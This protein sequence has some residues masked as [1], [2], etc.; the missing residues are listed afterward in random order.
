MDVH[1]IF[2][3][4]IHLLAAGQVHGTVLHG[5]QAVQALAGTVGHAGDGVVG[6]MGLDA[7]V[8]LDQ[9]IKA[10]QQGAAAGHHDTVSGDIGH[11]LGGRALQNG[12]DGL[13]DA[14]GDLLE[15]LDHLAGGDGTRGAG[16]SSGSG[17]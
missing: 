4:I 5:V 6:H 14:A 10:P 3:L 9:L 1:G 17:P 2:C 7:G 16:R 15:G 13:Q 12:V 8:G 11:Q